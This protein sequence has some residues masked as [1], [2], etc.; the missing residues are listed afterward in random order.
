MKKKSCLVIV[1][2]FSVPSSFVLYCFLCLLAPHEIDAAFLMK[3]KW[4]CAQCSKCIPVFHFTTIPISH[5][6]YPRS[7]SLNE[8]GTKNVLAKKWKI[9]VHFPTVCDPLLVSSSSLYDA[10]TMKLSKFE[11]C[12]CIKP[13]MWQ[14]ASKFWGHS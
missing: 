3:R 10:L 1:R 4:P 2:T 5:T 8:K 12:F 7:L 14:F 11:N 6:I 13:T 9:F